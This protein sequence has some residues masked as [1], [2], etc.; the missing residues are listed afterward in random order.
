MSSSVSF[1][2]DEQMTDE[3]TFE[4]LKLMT[5]NVDETLKKYLFRGWLVTHVLETQDELQRCPCCRREFKNE[6]S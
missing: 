4:Q 6:N 3:L 5:P 2:L 1:S